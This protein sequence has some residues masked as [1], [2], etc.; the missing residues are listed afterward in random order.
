MPTDYNN[1]SSVSQPDAKELKEKLKQL[2]ER[3]SQYMELL[4][5]PLSG[6]FNV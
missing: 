4:K 5:K 3:K 6:Q 2:E 1:E